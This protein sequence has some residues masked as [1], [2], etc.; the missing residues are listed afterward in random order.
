MDV[1]QFFFRLK[2]YILATLVIVGFF[3]M[4]NKVY[5]WKNGSF[6]TVSDAE[7]LPDLPIKKFRSS[8]FYYGVVAD[9]CNG[10]VIPVPHL[11]INES[12]SVLIEGWAVD[13]DQKQ[14]LSE[15]YMEVNDKYYPVSFRFS[16]DDV[17]ELL[18][19]EVG[20]KL[21]FSLHFDKSILKKDDGKWCDKINFYGVNQAEDSLLSPVEYKLLYYGKEPVEPYN[22][23][24]DV[25]FFLDAVSMGGVDLNNKVISFGSELYPFIYGWCFE[26]KLPLSDMLLVVGGKAYKTNYGIERQG[27]MD[28]FGLT[29]SNKVGFE[30]QIPKSILLKGDGTNVDYID[31]LY[32]YFTA[33][34]LQD[35]HLSESLSEIARLSVGCNPRSLKRLSNTLS[36]ISIINRKKTAEAEVVDTK[37]KTVDSLRA[38]GIKVMT[39]G[40]RFYYN[41]LISIKL[42]KYFKLY[43]DFF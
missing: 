19:M 42:V 14:P 33:E 3:F 16:R 26:S 10:D 15:M 20:N 41:P 36:L 29:E 37:S 39:L 8:D 31:F 9:V 24:A 27:V 17:A 30:I 7:E 12:D 23:N 40:S 1:K 11:L 35:Q 4:I 34:E 38:N 28:F 32:D 25:Q 22:Q 2:D 5:E 18:N 43:I 13:V 21:G 6:L